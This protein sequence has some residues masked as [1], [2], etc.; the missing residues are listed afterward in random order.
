MNE[1]NENKGEDPLRRPIGWWLRHVDGLLDLGFEATLGAQNVT[2]REWQILNGLAQGTPAAELLDS[3]N[4]FEDDG[5]HDALAGLVLRGWLRTGAD[6]GAVDIADAGRMQ[7]E[8]I[9]A[10]VRTMRTSVTQGLS[11][12]DYR[13]LVTGLARIAQNLERLIAGR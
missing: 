12:E 3:L 13:A 8:R 7:H 10:E 6:N 1:H 2:R 9:S 4:V 5:V 11:A